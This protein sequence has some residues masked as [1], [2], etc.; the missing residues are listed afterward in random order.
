MFTAKG[1]EKR[2][3]VFLGFTLLRGVPIRPFISKTLDGPDIYF[4]DINAESMS[5]K[6]AEIESEISHAPSR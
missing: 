5:E 2:V 6:I 4:E 1:I 3:L